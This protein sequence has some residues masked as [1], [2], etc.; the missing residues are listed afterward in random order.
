M[1]RQREAS[2]PINMFLYQVTNECERLADAA[3]AAAPAGDDDDDP[4]VAA[5]A[6]D[7]NTQA[8][9]RVRSR[10]VARHI[11]DDGWGVLPGMTWRHEKPLPELVA[12]G[13]SWEEGEEEEESEGEGEGEGEM[14]IAKA[15]GQ[16]LM[17]DKEARE[18]LL[19]Q[20][21]AAAPSKKKNRVALRA[22]KGKRAIAPW[23]FVRGSVQKRRH[24]DDGEIESF[25]AALA[26]R[27]ALRNARDRG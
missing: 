23:P 13:A 1:A 12:T 2:R 3:M 6:S 24:E 16:R 9:D 27:T 20:S 17:R 22:G 26:S 11:W 19:L 18:K 4:A 14:T 8:Y 25:Y 5:A 10:W 15:T 21:A 7:I